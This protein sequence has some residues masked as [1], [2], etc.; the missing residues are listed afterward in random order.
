MI[1]RTTFLFLIVVGVAAVAEAAKVT[2]LTI[3]C[4][5]R[6]E[7]TDDDV[8]LAGTRDGQPV[9][10]GPNHQAG[11]SRDNSLDMNEESDDDDAKSVTLD[12]KSLA[13]LSFNTD[14]TI[15]IKEKDVTEDQLLGTLHIG[16]DDG[17]KSVVLRGGSGDDAFE[18]RVD[19]TVEK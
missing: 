14:L 18:Y 19:Y 1:V 16:P 2:S 4:I 13:E 15:A 7:A 8:Y 3:H 12:V 5:N 9:P 10:W 17:K 6:Q 11:T